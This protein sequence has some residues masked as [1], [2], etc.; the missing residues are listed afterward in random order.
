MALTIKVN[1][2]TLCHKDSGGISTATAP[3]VCKTPT[4]GGPVPVPYPNIA[5]SKHLRKGTKTVKVDG[6]N[7][8]AVKGSEFATSTGDE[9][10]TAGGVK[11]GTFKKEATWLSFSPNVKMEGKNVCRLTDKMFHNH[12]NTVDIG[13]LRQANLSSGKWD[14][15][16]LLDILCKKDKK[17]VQKASK[18]NE[19]VTVEPLIFDDPIYENGKWTTTEFKAGGTQQPGKIQLVR[20]MSCERAALTLYHELVHSDQKGQQAKVPWSE[21]DA[22]TKT[23]E[24][25]IKR[26]LPEQQPGFRKGGKVDVQA[27]KKFVDKKYPTTKPSKPGGP[28]P[29][30][31][32]DRTPDGKQVYVRDSKGRVSLR[33][34]QEGDTYYAKKPRNPP[35]EKQIPPGDFKCP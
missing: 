17:E 28:I 26:G 16:C 8:A 5:F 10:G 34:V 23:E 2:L 25:A 33:P 35:K 30:Q 1:G 13:G 9:P 11:S 14:M 15:D 12:H 31:V 32:F 18:I 21:Y 29:P 19:I 22:Y 24:W 6:G 3:D 27:I 7:P 4:P 20:D